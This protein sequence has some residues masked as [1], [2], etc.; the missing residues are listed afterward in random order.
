MTVR[1]SKDNLEIDLCAESFES[2]G[3]AWRAPISDEEFDYFRMIANRE[4]GISIADYKRN[5]VFRRISKRARA[6]GFVHAACGPL[7]RSSY[8]ADQQAEEALAV[9]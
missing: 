5:M 2:H 9:N 4:A 6:L 3:T 7:V 1:T 8:H